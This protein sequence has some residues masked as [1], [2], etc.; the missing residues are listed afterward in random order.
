MWHGWGRRGTE[1]AGLGKNDNNTTNCFISL[2]IFDHS[3]YNI[4]LIVLSESDTNSNNI[5]NRQKVS[6]SEASWVI[7]CYVIERYIA[8]KSTDDEPCD[9]P[10]LL[11]FQLENK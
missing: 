10:V 8:N 7:T 11:F 1:A 3:Y 4:L 9:T 6:P 2:S 5:P